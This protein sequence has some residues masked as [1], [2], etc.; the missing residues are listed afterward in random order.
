M[1]CDILRCEILKK[2]SLII[3]YF[4]IISI[5]INFCSKLY[6]IFHKKIVVETRSK[7]A[8]YIY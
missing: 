4:V 8:K 3:A 2:K 1:F 6:L 5:F 7:I